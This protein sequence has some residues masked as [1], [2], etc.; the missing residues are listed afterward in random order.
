MPYSLWYNRVDC[1][2]YHRVPTIANDYKTILTHELVCLSGDLWD[3]HSG[4]LG[5]GTFMRQFALQTITPVYTHTGCHFGS[6]YFHIPT[7]ICLYFPCQCLLRQKC[8][9]K[10]CLLFHF[11][12]N[13]WILSPFHI[14]VS[15]L[16]PSTLFCGRAYSFPSEIRM[17]IQ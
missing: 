4:S 15:L 8:K 6:L 13:Q 16:V 7:N 14:L 9:V 11:S 2:W 3:I 10:Y 12:A 17:I 1:R 5:H